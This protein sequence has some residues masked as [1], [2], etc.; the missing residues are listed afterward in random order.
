M[1]NVF[2]GKLSTG[3]PVMFKLC[4]FV[5]IYTH[6]QDHAH[7]YLFHGSGLLKSQWCWNGEI[8][9]N[10]DF[11]NGAL[12]C[13]ISCHWLCIGSGTASASLTSSVGE[14]F[15][16]KSQASVQTGILCL[17]RPCAPSHVYMNIRVQLRHT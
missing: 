8:N 12:M 5:T 10:F 6:K 15:F 3:E 2:L 7:P 16:A 1:D 17:Y 4:S 14:G 11:F 13:I 9:E